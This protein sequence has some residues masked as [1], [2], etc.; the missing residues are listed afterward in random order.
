M[1]VQGLDI[2]PDSLKTFQGALAGAKTVLWN[3]PMG[4]FEWSSFAAGTLG[5]A[6]ALADLTDKA[7]RFLSPCPP[8][9]SYHAKANCGQQDGDIGWCC[10]NA[11][12]CFVLTHMH[13][14]CY[15]TRTTNHMLSA[16]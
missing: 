14:E 9:A 3:G 12:R 6:H 8:F 13:S 15:D 11:T 10:A 16:A 7:R 5:V 2:G 1:A 4:V